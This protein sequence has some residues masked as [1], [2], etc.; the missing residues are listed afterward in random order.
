MRD[1]IDVFY[2]IVPDVAWLRRVVP[3]GVRTIQLRL[4]DAPPERVSREI[5]EALEVCAGYGCQ[6]I[7]NDYW[8]EALAAGRRLHPPRPGGPR[9]RRR[10]C[11]QGQG[12]A[13]GD[14]HS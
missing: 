7:V 13:A 9:R 12:R 3:V 2:P 6:L 1:G 10:C 14:Q 4:K 8:R 5:G 11:D